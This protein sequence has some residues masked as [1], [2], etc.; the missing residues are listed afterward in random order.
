MIGRPAHQDYFYTF[1][2]IMWLSVWRETEHGYNTSGRFRKC[3]LRASCRVSEV[4][5]VVNTATPDV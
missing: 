2:I 4:N 1:Y 5:Y 3:Q